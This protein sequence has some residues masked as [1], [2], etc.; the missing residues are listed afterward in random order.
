MGN[1]LLWIIGLG[2]AGYLAYKYYF[3]PKWEKEGQQFIH[4]HPKEAKKLTQDFADIFK[5]SNNIN[6]HS[7]V[8]S[9]GYYY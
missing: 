6:K 5:I 4:Q 2:V 1:T 9:Y 7:N 8:S 3:L